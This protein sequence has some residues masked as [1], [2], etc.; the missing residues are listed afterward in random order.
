MRQTVIAVWA[1]VLALV[2][3]IEVL[4]VI[5]LTFVLPKGNPTNIVPVPVN[6]ETIRRVELDTRTFAAA[7][8]LPVSATDDDVGRTRI[9]ARGR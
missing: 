8:W 7:R 2:G 3:P 4:R 1:V 6:P 5:A 9:N